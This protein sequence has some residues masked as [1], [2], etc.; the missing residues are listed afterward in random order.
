MLRQNSSNIEPDQ[1]NHGNPIEPLPQRGIDIQQELNRLEEMIFASPHIPLTRRTLVDEELLLDHLDLLRDA[2][3]DVLQ[4]AKAVV[5]QKQDILLEAEQQAE[6]IIQLAKARAAQILSEMDIVQQAE[7]EAKQ[8]LQQVQ[9]E[10]ITATEQNRIEIEQVRRQAQQDLEQMRIRAIAE[11]EDIQQGADAYAD[12]VLRN[13]EQQLTE[14][15]RVV[16]NGRQQLNPI[17]PPE[18]PGARE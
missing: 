14:M 17:M 13:L 12:S 9:Q 16:H 8:I 10:C 2:L 5:E 3:P 4:K 15:L 7:A 1:N 6:E 11:A 18:L